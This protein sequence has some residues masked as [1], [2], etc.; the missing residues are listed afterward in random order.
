VRVAV[1][2]GSFNPPHVA[3][4]LAAAYVLSTGDVDRVLVVPVYEHAFEK[5]L[6]PFA[7]RL[8]M[9]EL[10]MSTLN[11][12]TVSDVERHLEPPSYTLHTLLH[13]EKIH[14]D[15]RMRL[16]VGADVLHEAPR[17]HAFERVCELAPLLP[18]GRVGVDHRDAPPAVLPDVSSTEVRAWLGQ[19][20]EPEAAEPGVAEPSVAE[21]SVAEPEAVEPGVAEPSVAERLRR[22]VPR[23]VL[24]YVDEHDLYRT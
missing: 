10:A 11:G 7:D 17:W 19:R 8:R 23:V 2:G 21:P 14:P 18:L 12:A 9:C 1:Y 4:V 3:H 24:A 6:A 15:W 5:Q 20:R 16:I 13:L 22:F